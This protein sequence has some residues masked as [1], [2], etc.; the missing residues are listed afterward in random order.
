MR[1]RRVI[2]AAVA[3]VVLLAAGPVEAAFTPWDPLLDEAWICY[4]RD[5]PKL[6]VHTV[7]AGDY[8][9][10]F[11]QA[12]LSNDGA[13]GMNA[14]RFGHGGQKT[15]HLVS[16]DL[17]G[18]FEAW[19]TGGKHYSDVLLLVAVHAADLPPD[20]AFTVNKEGDAPSRIDRGGF[21]YYDP[22]S[23]EYQCGRPTGLYPSVT[24]PPGEP[25]SYRFDA[26]WV[27]IFA[28]DGLHLGEAT[29]SVGIDYA[30]ENLPGRAVFSLYGQLGGTE[31]IRHTNR[32]LVDHND[33]A[34]PIST[35]EVVPEP[36][37]L[38]L[39]AC[40]AAGVPFRRPPWRRRTRQ[41]V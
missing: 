28:I 17:A 40:G 37:T 5:N 19:N 35:F 39:L 33:P 32:A 20:F 21:G 6:T 7:N 15:G 27:T 2:C 24:D 25:L 12:K 22:V 4:D 16:S 26:G 29:P 34:A 41:P 3:T 1:K 30:F 23:L 8:E 14:L 36:A 18:S 11:D 9:L 31:W 10:G 13:R 38:L